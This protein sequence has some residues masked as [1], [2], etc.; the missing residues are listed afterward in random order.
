MQSFD[1]KF[2]MHIFPDLQLLVE[3]VYIINTKI[4]RH[5][6]FAH[7][8]NKTYSQNLIGLHLPFQTRYLR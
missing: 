6:M 2:V 4:Y 1:T 7:T 5:Q 8:S 3:N